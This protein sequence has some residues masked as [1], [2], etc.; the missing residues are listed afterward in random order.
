MLDDQKKTIRALVERSVNRSPD[1][2]LL[3][4]KD[5]NLSYAQV[6]DKI[7]SQLS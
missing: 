5:E 2:T 1:K 3:T 7:T 4:F 6:F